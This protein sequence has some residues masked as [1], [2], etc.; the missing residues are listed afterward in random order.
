MLKAD[1]P[2]DDGLVLVLAHTKSMADPLMDKRVNAWTIWLAFAWKIPP[3]AG[4]TNVKENETIICA[5]YR[6][7]LG[8]FSEGIS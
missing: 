3:Q 4:K 5:M 8:E 2:L 1:P 7:L 6:E